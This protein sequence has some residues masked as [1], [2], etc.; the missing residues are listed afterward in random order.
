MHFSQAAPAGGLCALLLALMVIDARQVQ[1]QEL[2]WNA[3]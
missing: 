1:K 3:W 2:I